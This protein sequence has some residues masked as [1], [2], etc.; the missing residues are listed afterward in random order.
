[1]ATNA[2]PSVSDPSRVPDLTVAFRELQRLLITTSELDAFLAALAS[3]AVE[4]ISPVS[5]CGITLRRN[6]EPMTVSSS[7]PLARR[8]DE[9]QYGRGV[10]P[11][12]QALH[13]GD[14]VSVTD[15]AE[16]QRWGD[17]PRDALSWGVA[18]SLSL[19]LTA[20]APTVG[21]MNLYSVHPH[22]FTAAEIAQG[23][24]FAAQASGALLLVAR[25]E[26]LLKV[27]AQLRDALASRAVIDQAMGVLMGTRHISAT[28]AFDALRSQ[29]QHRN[30][31]LRT[32]AADVVAT[33]TNHVAEKA[34]AFTQRS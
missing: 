5:S 17:Y 27:N 12:L 33:I 8:I 15:L 23:V 25:H 3:L 34:P 4:L 28:E 19:P 18:A 32:V 2:S 20:G 21:A 29:S 1:M 22:E 11:C 7:D 31:K 6:G 24:S 14:I 16:E 26:S 10:G 9:L 30:V 13:T